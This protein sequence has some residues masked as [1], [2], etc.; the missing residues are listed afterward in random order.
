M[1]KCLTRYLL[2]GRALPARQYR[3][4]ELGQDEF[5]HLGRLVTFH[6]R[7]DPWL[8]LVG[9]TDRNQIDVRPLR[10]LA[11]DRVLDGIQSCLGR[12]GGVD[13][14]GAC[15]AS[16]FIILIFWGLSVMPEI[17]VLKPPPSFSL[18]PSLP[19]SRSR[20]PPP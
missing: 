14:R 2:A 5:L 17:C 18:M 15:A 12:V 8:V 4:L 6:Q 11:K 13:P 7:L 9:R 20:P 1:V 19:R 16:F 3:A 10:I